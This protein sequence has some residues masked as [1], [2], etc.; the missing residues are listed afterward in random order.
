MVSADFFNRYAKH[1]ALLL[2]MPV[3]RI[4][5]QCTTN[6]KSEQTLIDARWDEPQTTKVSY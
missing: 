5:V 3:N 6:W 1:S 2:V 4:T